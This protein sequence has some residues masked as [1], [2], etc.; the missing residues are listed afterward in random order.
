MTKFSIA[1]LKGAIYH[2]KSEH[3][4]YLRCPYCRVGNLV[5]FKT[6]KSDKVHEWKCSVC[7]MFLVEEL[8]IK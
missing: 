7:G 1:G 5:F 4:E 3:Q 2:F 8:S 6:R